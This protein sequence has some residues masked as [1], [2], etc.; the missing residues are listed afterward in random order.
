MKIKKGA[1]VHDCFL[2]TGT[3]IDP[4]VHGLGLALVQWDKTPPAKYNGG[5][6]PCCRFVEGLTTVAPDA[7]ATRQEAR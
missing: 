1:R 7:A 3:V 2:G 5:Q 6:N 4:D